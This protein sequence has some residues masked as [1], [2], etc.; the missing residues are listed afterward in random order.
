MVRS[1]Y[2]CCVKIKINIID[3]NAHLGIDKITAYSH[4]H[5]FQL[6][7]SPTSLFL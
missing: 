6:S 5:S 2:L 7:I 4:V 1:I 3:Y